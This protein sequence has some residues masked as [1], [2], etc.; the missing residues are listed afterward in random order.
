MGGS[1]MTITLNNTVYRGGSG[2]PLVLLHAFPVDHRMWDECVARLMALASDQGGEPFPIWAP[3]MPG[4]GAGSIPDAVSTGAVATDGAYCEALDVLADAY[5]GLL[6]REG[7]T[8]AVWVGLSMGGYEALDI[9]RRHPQAVAG[10]GLC[11]TR[12]DTD[13]AEG[14][15][16]RLRIARECE[17]DG[18][19]D[20]V[21]HF[22]QPR[23]DDSTVKRSGPFI[24]AM[25]GWIND[26]TPEGVAWRER[27][28]AGRPELSAQLPLVTAPAALVSGELDPSSPPTVMKRM[29]AAMTASETV[30][31]VIEDC[32][33][34]S[35][36][37]H[38]DIVA[39]ALLAL[40]RRAQS[41][42]QCD[43]GELGNR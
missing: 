11:D 7:F 14:R 8:K 38:P 19:V 21:M 6:Q 33:H 31:T 36:V 41:H 34:F 9:Q 26:Q 24:D 17:H 43:Q 16:N 29:A 10:I 28:A 1:L 32:G 30:F 25:T 12:A 13:G 2:T 37:E 18:T 4:A 20:S 35:A 3:D 5:V 27:T 40:V 42:H 23:P 15:A 39:S 22:A